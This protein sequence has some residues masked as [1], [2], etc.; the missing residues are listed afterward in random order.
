MPES[1]AHRSTRAVFAAVSRR[2]LAF[3]G[4]TSITARARAERSEPGVSRPARP[5]IFA[6]TARASSSSRYW[7]SRTISS[8]LPRVMI[9]SASASSVAPSRVARCHAT[10]SSQSAAARDSPSA[11]ASW[12]RVNSC[13]TGG[14]RPGSGSNPSSGLR[15]NTSAI[16]TSLRAAAWASTRSKAHTSPIS[17]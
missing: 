15:R 13:T 10:V 6:S 17:S 14:I 12:S 7:V 11:R 9:P 2:C 5:R 16:A 8:A 3:S 4:A 1:S